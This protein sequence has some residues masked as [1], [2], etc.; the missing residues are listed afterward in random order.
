MT[1]ATGGTPPAV[2]RV[3]IVHGYRASPSAHWFPWLGEQLAERG[4]RAVTVDLPESTAPVAAAWEEAVAAELGTPDEAT[5]I[6]THS[7]GGITALRV[8]AALPDGW[9]LG[10]L[11]L[12]AGFTGRLSGL[13]ELDGYLAEG[14]HVERLVGGIRV[15][16]M[17]R[18]DDDTQ[19]PPAASDELARRL[20]AGIHVQE[21]A[22]HFLAT[23]GITTLP[24]ITRILAESG[25]LP[26]GTT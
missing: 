20:D 22:G 25:S 6:V 24:L 15:R 13:P 17:I 3:V 2:E 1:S 19:V 23:E 4:V 9:R 26:S 5:W 16:A 18:S 21:G 8:L 10:G 12:V 7:L 14:V 11:V